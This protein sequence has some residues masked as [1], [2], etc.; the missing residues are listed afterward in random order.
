M[1]GKFEIKPA[2]NGKFMFNLK[3]GNGQ[4]ILTSNL[5]DDLAGAKAAAEAARAAAGSEASFERKT[6]SANEPYFVLKGADG[7][8]LGRSEMY[9][10]TTAMENGI[11][12]VQ[13]N[14]PDAAV[15][16]VAG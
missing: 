2:A 15:V 4:V 10:A 11:D 9:S 16:E 8:T 5:H 14:A 1:A 7:G 13:K 12:S 3:A 6:S